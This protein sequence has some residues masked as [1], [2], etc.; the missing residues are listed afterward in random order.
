[1]DPLIRENHVIKMIIELSNFIANGFPRLNITSF[2]CP[3]LAAVHEFCHI[4]TRLQGYT[5]GQN[6]YIYS[7]VCVHR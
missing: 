2:V 4:S 3:K 5:F 7:P 1:M 6:K